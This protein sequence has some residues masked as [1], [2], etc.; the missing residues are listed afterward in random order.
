MNIQ[1]SRNAFILSSIFSSSLSFGQ[2]NNENPLD[3]RP[4]DDLR[5]STTTQNVPSEKNNL[6]NINKELEEQDSLTSNSIL[7][8][9]TKNKE[10]SAKNR[11]KVN[12]K[13]LDGIVTVT[14]TVHSREEADWVIQQAQAKAANNK[15]VDD[16]IIVR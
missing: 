1:F 15:V 5:P 2:Y 3:Y 9:I 8:N 14:G 12:V 10:F 4:T 7:Q 16:L 13:T 11:N 6:P